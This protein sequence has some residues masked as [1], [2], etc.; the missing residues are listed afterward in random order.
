MSTAAT[1]LALKVTRLSLT[2][3]LALICL[4][5]FYNDD[6]Q[7]AWMKQSTLATIM[8]CNRTTA[9]RALQSLEEK[10]LIS[11]THQKYGD[12]RN[13]P[14]EYYL[15]FNAWPLLDSAGAAKLLARVLESKKPAATV[16][17]S[18]TATVANTNTVHVAES[19]TVRDDESNSKN[20]KEYN[21]VA[22]NVPPN[23]PPAPKAPVTRSPKGD[24]HSTND[25]RDI[26][27][28][29]RGPLPAIR[30]LSEA[31]RRKLRNL[32][33]EFGPNEA[34]QMF[35]AATRAVAQNDFWIRRGYG[36][37]NLLRGKVEQYAE[38]TIPQN[39]V[40]TAA[41]EATDFLNY[42][43]RTRS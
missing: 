22:Y 25:Y 34:R 16:A 20:Y 5:D 13:A 35:R 18:N 8:C 1:G 2:E 40:S 4:S 27:N 14:K 6:K 36:F 3:K 15:H 29:N 12:G 37:D 42:L 28:E 17:E 19:N 7:R 31:R 11:S 23:S 26:W 30:T 43:E 10:G 41:K 9:N 39:P 38:Q 33:K 21:G 24:T 32:D